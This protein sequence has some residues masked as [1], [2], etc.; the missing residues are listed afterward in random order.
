MFIL[1]FRDNSIY[2]WFSLNFEMRKSRP[3]DSAAGASIIAIISVHRFSKLHLL[4]AI[5]LRTCRL[6]GSVGSSQYDSH[7]MIFSVFRKLLY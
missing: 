5:Q 3:G 1:L 2:I 6:C 4:S 7:F